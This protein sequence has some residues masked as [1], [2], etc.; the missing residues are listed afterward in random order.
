MG[1][2]DTA[3]MI[4]MLG[5]RIKLAPLVKQDGYSMRREEFEVLMGP[6]KMTHLMAQT[7]GTALIGMRLFASP[8]M[9]LR[10]LTR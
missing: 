3:I 7:P 8:E 9:D 1:T 4:C 6:M 10:C 2:E 5:S